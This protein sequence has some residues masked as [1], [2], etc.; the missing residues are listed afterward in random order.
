LAGDLRYGAPCTPAIQDHLTFLLDVVVV[1][2]SGGGSADDGGPEQ[3]YYHIRSPGTAT[4]DEER[5]L[6]RTLWLLEAYP[7]ELLLALCQLLRQR[8]RL[9]LGLVTQL[10]RATERMAAFLA[11]CLVARVRHP[12]LPGL[13]AGHHSG[14]SMGD[15]LSEIRDSED[16]VLLRLRPLLVAA[17]PYQSVS[18]MCL[19]TVPVHAPAFAASSS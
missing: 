1:V 8:P 6:A 4:Q 7:W 10:I 9:R 11:L 3:T 5:Y 15:F 14:S 16:D 2:F 17:Q 19:R 13:Q 18:P 12:S